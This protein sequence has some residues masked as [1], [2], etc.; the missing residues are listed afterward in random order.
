MFGKFSD[1]LAY[2]DAMGKSGEPEE[3]SEVFYCRNFLAVTGWACK[4]TQKDW[5]LVLRSRFIVVDGVSLDFFW[6]KY[7]SREMLWR[8]YGHIPHLEEVTFG[9][10]LELMSRGDWD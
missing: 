6:K 8:R 1:V 3:F 7:S 4:E 9:G 5:D 2:W 10:W